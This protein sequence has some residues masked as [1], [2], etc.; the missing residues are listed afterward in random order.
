MKAFAGPAAPCVTLRKVTKLL[1]FPMGRKFLR[2]YPISHRN[3]TAMRHCGAH[4]PHLEWYVVTCTGPAPIRVSN[5]DSS[6][7]I[8]RSDRYLF[9]GDQF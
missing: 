8:L 1:P 3:R 7:A 5:Y 4:P 6:L 2:R 9:Q